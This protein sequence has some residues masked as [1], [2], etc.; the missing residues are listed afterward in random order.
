[1][2]DVRFAG[3]IGSIALESVGGSPYAFGMWNENLKDHLNLTESEVQSIGSVG[4]LGLYASFFAGFGIIVVGEQLSALIGVAL[5]AL[6]YLLLHLA[7]MK[8]IGHS[9]SLLT[10]YTVIAFH[11]AGWLDVTAV[12][13]NVTNFPMDGGLIMGLLKSMWGLS[14]SIYSLCYS[15]FYK[16]DVSAILLFMGLLHVAVVVPTLPFNRIVRAVPDEHV[17]LSVPQENKVKSAY[18]FVIIISLYLAILSLINTSGPVYVYFLLPL[19]ALHISLL[20]VWP[21]C[22]QENE[23]EY[24]R[25]KRLGDDLGNHINVSPLS[26]HGST[27]TGS[28]SCSSSDCGVVISRSFETAASA[29]SVNRQDDCGGDA[30]DGEPMEEQQHQHQQRLQHLAMVDV[31]APVDSVVLLN[32]K[33]NLSINYHQPTVCEDLFSWDYICFWVT[34]F[35]GTGAG[36]TVINNVGSL[37]VSIGGKD[38][39]QVNYVSILSVGNCMGRMLFGYL[40]D[41]HAHFM[42]RPAWLASLCVVLSAGLLFMAFADLD[43]LHVSVFIVGTA[44]GGFWSIGPALL[45]DRFGQ[46]NFSPLYG[47]SALSTTLGAYSLNS[48][49]QSYVYRSHIINPEDPKNT[50]C[51]GIVCFQTTLLVLFALNL[52]GALLGAY[53]SR[54]IAFAY[55]EHGKVIPLSRRSGQAES[56]TIAP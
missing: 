7:A 5:V 45:S 8:Q 4:D 42:T 51:Y 26:F 32:D 39:A 49:L 2:D 27:D 31:R 53:L 29:A 50:T 1:M 19:V 21:C 23:S 9:V 44:Y 43:T 20:F 35:C 36:L 17:K 38:G 12:T 47:F 25:L 24:E 46:K 37:V 16:P 3:L 6:G 56:R 10:L 54:R 15:S 40:S 14:A 55:D 48:G 28:G 52:A 41:R 13:I 22:E 34:Y 33:D 11:G 18:F 30:R